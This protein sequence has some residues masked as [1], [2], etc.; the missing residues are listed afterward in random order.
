MKI[1]THKLQDRDIPYSSLSA[2]AFSFVGGWQMRLILTALRPPRTM[3]NIP[4][5]MKASERERT[6]TSFPKSG[7][8]ITKERLPVI[9]ATE[10]AVART[11]DSIRR[12]MESSSSGKATPRRKAFKNIKGM[13]KGVLISPTRTKV[14]A[15]RR[16]IYKETFCPSFVSMIWACLEPNAAESWKA[17]KIIPK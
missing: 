6:S 5:M 2:I 11:F 17:A 15:I 10:S 1:L 4:M 9:L 12:F 8:T 16:R 7:E 14:G 13:S 3:K